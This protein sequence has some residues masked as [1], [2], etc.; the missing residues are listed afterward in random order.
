MAKS[1]SILE[2]LRIEHLTQVED[3]S[4]SI[5]FGASVDHLIVLR[6]CL[7]LLNILKEF[8]IL[9]KTGFGKFHKIPGQNFP[10]HFR[11]VPNEYF[12]KVYVLKLILVPI[13][14]FYLQRSPRNSLVKWACFAYFSHSQLYMLLLNCS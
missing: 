6:S 14:N 5:D 13:S 11:I 2:F 8:N 9:S 10:D 12:L 4:P 3:F 7:L 1:I